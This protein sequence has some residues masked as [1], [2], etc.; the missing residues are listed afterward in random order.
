MCQTK[1]AKWTG[2]KVELNLN[3]GAEPYHA[4]AFPVP[5]CHMETLKREVERLCEI[6]VLK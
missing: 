4:R 3:K 1:G 6:G 5:R 2:T